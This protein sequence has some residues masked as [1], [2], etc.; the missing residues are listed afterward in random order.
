VP[1]AAA[2]GGPSAAAAVHAAPL[3]GGVRVMSAAA[4]VGLGGL[5]PRDLQAAAAPAPLRVS[6]PSSLGN[7]T[8]AAY[9]VM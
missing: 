1:A 4:R 5:E 2:A 6:C 7:L 8:A 9:Q 3:P